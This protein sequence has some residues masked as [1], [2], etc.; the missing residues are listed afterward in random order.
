MGYRI[1]PTQTMMYIEL[2]PDIE[3]PMLAEKVE[4]VTSLILLRHPGTLWL[5]KS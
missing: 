2:M 1:F 5:P 3:L 4:I